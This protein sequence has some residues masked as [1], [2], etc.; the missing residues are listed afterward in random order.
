MPPRVAQPWGQESPNYAQSEGD[1]Q[2]P[3][4]ETDR[5]AALDLDLWLP[6]TSN[7]Q[8]LTLQVQ[9]RWILI[10]IHHIMNGTRTMADVIFDQREGQP[11]QPPS[12][13]HLSQ[14]RYVATR[15]L[16]DMGAYTPGDPDLIHW[17]VHNKAA[18]RIRE[19][20]LQHNI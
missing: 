5:L 7:V 14:W 3:S 10:D 18:L 19:A 16:A 12:M 2:R 6:R 8:Q 4:A 15:L 13:Q 11:A 1:A 20:L 9:S 17:R